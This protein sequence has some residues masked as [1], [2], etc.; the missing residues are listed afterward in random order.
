MIEDMFKEIIDYKTG[1]LFSERTSISGA[2]VSRNSLIKQLAL[3]KRIRENAN[4]DEDCCDD[5]Y[6]DEAEEDEEDEDEEEIKLG[7]QFE[8]TPL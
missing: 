6:E 3:M 5:E 1:V 8:I 7:P 4:I 2:F